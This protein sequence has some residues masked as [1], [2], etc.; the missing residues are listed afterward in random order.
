MDLISDSILLDNIMKLI[1]VGIFWKDKDRR[2]LGAN[3]MFLD[4]YGLSSVDEIIGKNDED[5]GWH[6][7]P[8][9]FKKIEL[10]VLNNGKSVLDVPGE[11]I[12]KGKLR[13]IKASKCPIISDGK[14]VGSML[15]GHDGRHGSFYHVCVHEDYRKH[16]I[17][18]SMAS[19][20][21]MRLKNEGISKIQLVAFKG[22]QLGNSFWQAEQW[23]EREDYNVYDFVLNDENI[24]AFNK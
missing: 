5:M 2:F 17:G 14:I 6:I 9:P 24:I 21:M 11:C 7:N 16:G 12:V 18:K 23:T 15:V 8:E 13:K 22:N 10:R 4:Y 1:P 3:Q 19:E 20:A